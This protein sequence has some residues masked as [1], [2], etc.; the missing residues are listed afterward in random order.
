MKT[1]ISRSIK[2]SFVA[3]VVMAA[4]G[5]GAESPPSA[6]RIEI[7]ETPVAA[8]PSGMPVLRRVAAEDVAWKQGEPSF[9]MLDGTFVKARGW[10]ALS[11]NST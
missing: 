7:V 5:W 11:E 8:I 4:P 3:L 1:H 10:L 2:L 6:P 9:T